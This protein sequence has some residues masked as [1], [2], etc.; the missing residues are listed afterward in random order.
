MIDRGWWEIYF[1]NNSFLK[2]FFILFSGEDCGVNHG[3]GG[4]TIKNAGV[5][6]PF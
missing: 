4:W 1:E 3:L 5:M 2:T 6:I